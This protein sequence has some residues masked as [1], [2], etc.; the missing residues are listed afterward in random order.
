MAEI[1]AD[2]AKLDA[3]CRLVDGCDKAVE[4]A[5]SSGISDVEVQTIRDSYERLI[6]DNQRPK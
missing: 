1:R 6:E 2:R 5:K 4:Q 3:L